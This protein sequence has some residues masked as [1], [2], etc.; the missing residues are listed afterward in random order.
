LPA[1]IV[2]GDVGRDHFADGLFFRLGHVALVVPLDLE[3]E[4]GLDL[5]RRHSL[6][7]A[8][9][10]ARDQLVEQMDVLAE[11]FRKFEVSAFRRRRHADDQFFEMHRLGGGQLQRVAKID[12]YGQG[13]GASSDHRRQC[14]QI[15]HARDNHGDRM[16]I[17][18]GDMIGG[19]FRP[20]LLFQASLFGLL[21]EVADG[22]KQESAR[23]ASRIENPLLDRPFDRMAHDLRG[24]PV[25]G[26][27]FA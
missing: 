25:W 3:L 16:N 11:D 12:G 18:A 17:H 24:Q 19:L 21:D 26:V 10:H 23:A 8:L 9:P 7:G 2:E 1:E 27:I 5:A 14:Q 13:A 4:S 22:V 6:F 20:E 15:G